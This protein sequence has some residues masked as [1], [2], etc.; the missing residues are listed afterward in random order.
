[1]VRIRWQVGSF[2]SLEISG[3][4]VCLRVILRQVE[5][6]LTM[7]DDFLLIIIVN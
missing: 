7:F 2:S 4:S 5:E 6:R 1:M 3:E